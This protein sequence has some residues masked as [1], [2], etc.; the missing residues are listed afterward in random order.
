MHLTFKYRVDETTIRVRSGIREKQQTDVLWSQIRAANIKRNVLDR[1]LGLA[2]VSFDTAGSQE[3]EIEIPGLRLANAENLAER[4]KSHRSNGAIESLSDAESPHKLDTDDELVKEEDADEAVFQLSRNDL[5]RATFC[6]GGEIAAILKGFASLAGMYVLY[7]AVLDQF[8]EEEGNIWKE[9]FGWIVELPQDFLTDIDSWSG[10]IQDNLGLSIAETVAGQAALLLAIVLVFALFFVILSRLRFFAANYGL[11]VRNNNAQLVA[12][13]GLFSKSRVTI[14][15]TRV[16]E[17]TYEWNLRE[18][19]FSRG[20]LTMQQSLSGSD[21]KLVVPFV[22][23]KTADQI[24]QRAYGDAFLDST[25]DPYSQH[26]KRISRVDLYIDLAGVLLVGT[27]VVL[28]ALATLVPVARPFLW[29]YFLLFP[30]LASLN[31][32]AM[33]R[34]QGYILREGYITSRGSGWFGIGY[35][36]QN[37]RLEKVQ[38]LSISQTPIQRPRQT[39]D[40]QVSFLTGTISVPYLH[41]D[42]ARSMQARILYMIQREESKWT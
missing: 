42:L 40:F 9:M 20:N 13:R 26:Y 34:K 31:N 16:Q 19:M 18:R 17:V 11:V 39:C 28:A 10:F 25:L 15:K 29:P 1:L 4:V 21:H 27:P 5:W 2:S 23:T 14:K 30:I 41:T 36:V 35:R 37:V 32:W 33:W 3:A 8:S 38:N 22:D 12:E 24:M 7:R 6:L